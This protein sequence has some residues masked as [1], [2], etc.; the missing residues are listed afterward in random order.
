[1]IDKVTFLKNHCGVVVTLFNTFVLLISSLYAL[2]LSAISDRQKRIFNLGIDYYNECSTS[3]TS[4]SGDINISSDVADANQ[5]ADEIFKALTTH[6]FA[7][8]GN[9]P[10]NAVQA[11][12]ILG[13]LQ[14]ESGFNPKSGVPN[15]D[16]RGI[17][18]WDK[19]NRWPKIAEP[20][21]LKEQV[22]FMIQEMDGAYA[23]G[24]KELW[25]AKTVGDLAKATFAWARNYEI[26]IQNGGGKTYWT[27]Q[28]DALSHIQGWD[29]QSLTGHANPR[30]PNAQAQYNRYKDQAPATSAG[31]SSSSSTSST[32]GI[33][34]RIVWVGDS[35]TVGMHEAISDTNNAWIA[36]VSKG[37]DW[38]VNTAL[39]QVKSTLK[40]GDTIVLPLVLMI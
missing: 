25:E 13:N 24:L 30:W 38:F 31:S 36:E 29:K 35:R 20:K 27:S 6:N 14:S 7:H 21:G 8:N 2:P 4:S 11:A 32:S 23:A 16:F 33:S 17:A 9:K 1:M 34:G 5:A 18:Q 26:A 28:A 3:G 10:L 12:A 40:E 19:I 15:G 39:G 22:E 37:Y